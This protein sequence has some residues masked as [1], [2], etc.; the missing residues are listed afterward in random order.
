MPA[1]PCIVG[2]PELRPHMACSPC[3]LLVPSQPP[4][5]DRS[6]DGPPTW[7]STEFG[8][9]SLVMPWCQHLHV[10]FLSEF[11]SSA[12]VSMQVSFG[13]AFDIQCEVVSRRYLSVRNQ[14]A[15]APPWPSEAP[16]TP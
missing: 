5:P 16:H 11:C 9:E 13:A 4:P 6:L 15:P 8:R 3:S 14:S 10:C 1:L 2:D 7:S 12:G